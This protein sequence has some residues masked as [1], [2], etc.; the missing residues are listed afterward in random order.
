MQWKKEGCLLRSSVPRARPPLSRT[1]PLVQRA[2]VRAH[3]KKHFSAIREL[4]VA[5]LLMRLGS[6]SGVALVMVAADTP[7]VEEPRG[8]PST[9]IAAYERRQLTCAR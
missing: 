7:C 3:L 9:G 8:L 1:C 4:F 2:F 6:C 5:K